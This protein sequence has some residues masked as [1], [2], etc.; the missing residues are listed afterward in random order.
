MYLLL[1]L[2]VSDSQCACLCQRSVFMS[3]HC[4]YPE[5][6]QPARWSKRCML[7]FSPSNMPWRHHYLQTYCIQEPLLLQ[8]GTEDMDNV[9]LFHL[10]HSQRDQF[11]PT[12][13]IRCG[14]SHCQLS[15]GL[16]EPSLASKG[17]YL[18]CHALTS[19]AHREEVSMKGSWLNEGTG[20]GGVLVVCEY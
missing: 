10:H 7:Y 17:C 14:C 20:R 12:C 2:P 5:A 3:H 9:K 19:T 18:F 15:R 1:A 13:F 4:L 16:Y 6:Q 11:N 8:N